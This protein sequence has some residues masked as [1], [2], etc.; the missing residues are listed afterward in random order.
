[1]TTPKTTRQRVVD[2]MRGINRHVTNPIMLTFA[3]RRVYA[4]A[5]HVGRRSGRNYRTPVLAVPSGEGVI[6]PLPYGSSGDW[7]P[8]VA[9]AQGCQLEWN[10]KEYVMVEP[11][12]VDRQFAMR[13]FP[14]GPRPL[15]RH[16]HEFLCLRF[17][18]D[19]LCPSW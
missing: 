10:G 14:R 9:A 7:S 5:R 16:T 17:A 6:I 15:L 13:A 18:P 8:N 12:L 4:V 3:G 19:S 11:R 2:R 1:M